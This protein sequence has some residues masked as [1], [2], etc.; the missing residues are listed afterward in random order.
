L[1]LSGSIYFFSS[2]DVWARNPSLF[3]LLPIATNLLA[4]GWTFFVLLPY[5]FA[6]KDPAEEYSEATEQRMKSYR[7][8]YWQSAAY[9]S[10]LLLACGYMGFLDKDGIL[11]FFMIVEMFFYLVFCTCWPSI[12]G[13]MSGIALNVVLV[14]VSIALYSA[15]HSMP[16]S[17]SGVVSLS[18]LIA[19]AAL[20]PFCLVIVYLI[21]SLGWAGFRKEVQRIKGWQSLRR[22][23]P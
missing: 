2:Q 10:V 4:A 11:Y 1:L 5:G 15:Y 22:S 14:S 6:E 3:F 13:I 8:K 18:I 20:L 23:T 9:L 16:F 17:L 7:T 21:L 19:L 12:R